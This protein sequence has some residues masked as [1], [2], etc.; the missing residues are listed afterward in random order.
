MTAQYQGPE[1]RKFLRL[2]YNKP[3]DYKICK[4]ET[5]SKLLQG[6]TSDI[7]ASGLLCNIK[8][9]VKTG[10]IIWLSFD[11]ATLHICEELEKNCLIYQNGIIGKIARVHQK[12]NGTFDIGVKFLTREEQHAVSAFHKDAKT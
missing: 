9:E 7:S 12:T 4:K 11:R 10:D 6:Y 3:L 1:R 2:E 5:L 8:E